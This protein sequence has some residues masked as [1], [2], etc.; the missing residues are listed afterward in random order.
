MDFKSFKTAVMAAAEEKGLTEYE[1]YF[2]AC[3]ALSV[4]THKQE[5]NQFSA[6]T[7]GGACFRCIVNGKMGYA[8]TENLDPALATALVDRAMD[9]ASVL[10]SEEQVFLACGGQNYRKW[11]GRNYPLPNAQQLI[12][13]VLQTQKQLYDTDP[14][15]VD[16]STTQGVTEKTQIAICNS[17]GL[18]VKMEVGTSGLVIS[19][20]VQGDGEK[21]ND[22]Q[23][24]LD[25]LDKI[26][27]AELTKKAVDGAKSKLGGVPAPTGTYPVV[28]D[29]DAMS[30]LLSV[31]SG[32]FSSEA[33]QKGLSRFADKEGT[34]VASEVVTLMDDPFHPENP[35]PMCFDSEGSPTATKAV[36][37][38]GELK[39][40]LY[41]LKTA[42]VAGKT[43]T[44]NASKGG[45]DAPVKVSPFTFYLCGGEQTE[46]ELLQSVGN[47]VYVNALSGLHAGANPVTGDFSLQSA[48]FMI[49]NG[50][51]TY[52]VKSFTVAGN[53][54]ELLKNV[55][56]VANNMQL[57]MATGKTAF[58]APTTWVD[59]LTVA[60]K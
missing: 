59:G 60:G 22:Y 35:M 58:G 42:H 25:Q 13:K 9:N 20:V 43:T 12:E 27:V 41:N 1:L 32:V 10:E 16:G 45:Y 51:K 38:K 11:A 39:T 31:F 4:N 6:E 26:D 14:A 23:L 44:G 8:A 30:S 5:I 29:P 56:A 50:Q 24:K 3:E 53:F 40:L 21:A 55:K 47:G 33:A 18:D 2:Q 48:G 7:E 54:Y 37:S 46:Q 36:V 17:K 28:F 19:A 57:P 52:A 34:V 15:V 49:E